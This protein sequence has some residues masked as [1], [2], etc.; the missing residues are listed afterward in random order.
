LVAVF[1]GPVYTS[2]NN[3]ATW[4]QTGAP[5]NNWV[6]VASSA[7]GTRLV[8][9]ANVSEGH[10][11]RGD[12]LIYTSA[13]SGTTWTQT[14]AP[15]NN[16]MSVASS[17]DGNPLVALADGLG[18]PGQIYASVDSGATW[19]NANAPLDNWRAVTCSAS[20]NTIVA[21]ASGLIYTLHLPATS[22]APSSRPLRLPF[23]TV[24]P[25]DAKMLISW[26][27]PS[28]S[29]ML[30][31]ISDSTTTNWKD[32]PTFPSL[33]FTNLHYEVSVAPTNA[34]N[35]YRLKQK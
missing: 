10:L 26:L 21:V 19:V 4:T 17:A 12:G 35:F 5:S 1:D 15:F 20:G 11:I 24:S 30:Q 32:V 8:A 34:G 31:Q 23:L 27:V 9:A 33:N 16:W 2:T 7:D 13:D 25:S 22:P 3:G 29:F 28:S 14:T 18:L 6:S